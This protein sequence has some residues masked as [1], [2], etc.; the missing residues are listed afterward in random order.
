MRLAL[1]L[2]CV[3]GATPW[4]QVEAVGGWW[5]R[6]FD[7]EVDVVGADRA[8]IADRIYFAGSIKW[9]GT[10]FDQHDLAELM[11]GSAEVPGFT[12][13]DTG[14]AVV[15]LS[16]IAPTVDPGRVDLRWGPDDVVSAW[17]SAA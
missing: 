5:N 8:P 7:P 14:V 9:L 3:V 4:P 16:G 2:A 15:S 6:K 1:E 10:P 13:G 11:R 12:F 17:Q